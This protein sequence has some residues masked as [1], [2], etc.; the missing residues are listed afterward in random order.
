MNTLIAVG[1]LLLMLGSLLLI[2]LGLP[3]LWMVVALILGL[4]LWGKVSWALL[5]TALV[6]AAAAEAGEFAV[7]RAYGKRYGGSN[8]AFWGAVLG[9][10]AGLFVGVP[11]PIVGPLITAFV[12]SFLG[13]GVVTWFETRS[14]SRSGQ[15][16]WG[17]V[18]A[19]TVAVALKVGVG[20]ALVAATGVSLL[21]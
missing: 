12:G 17:V 5:V 10:M 11:V 6:A 15:V 14:L 21:L 9:G 20:A 7:V 16:G 4:T 2:P 18:V 1:V 3:G 19:R 8:R 13:A